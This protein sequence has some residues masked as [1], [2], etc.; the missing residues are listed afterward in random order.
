MILHQTLQEM[1]LNASQTFKENQV[2]QENREREAAIEKQKFEEEIEK[3]PNLNY[4]VGSEDVK[5]IQKLGFTILSYYE[6][7]HP[8][9]DSY[10]KMD[11][12]LCEYKDWKFKVEWSADPDIDEGILALRDPKNTVTGEELDFYCDL[13]CNNTANKSLENILT[14]FEIGFEHFIQQEY[15]QYLA[16]PSLL[17]EKGYKVT[18]HDFVFG[19]EDCKGSL[20]IGEGVFIRIYGVGWQEDMSFT[21]TNDKRWDVGSSNTA[22]SNKKGYH[23]DYKGKEDIDELCLCIE[24]F[25]RHIKGT[26]GFKETRLNTAE[27][28]VEVYYKNDDFVSIFESIR[29]NLKKKYYEKW[30]TNF[31]RYE[32]KSKWGKHA[33]KR[34]NCYKGIEIAKTVT[35]SINDSAQWT[36]GDKS[37]I[38]Q[39]HLEYNVKKN[40]ESCYLKI[41]Q[42][43]SSEEERRYVEE[44]WDEKNS[45]CKSVYEA[46]G[47]FSELTEE[48]KEFLHENLKHHGITL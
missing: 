31:V 35:F 43:I 18:E 22:S 11:V 23:F 27:E 20:E 2:M 41:S 40:V 8:Y 26:Y 48:V 25:K 46:Y 32:E 13:F 9:G 1:I 12:Y 4:N 29:R 44:Q 21:I 15:H 38:Y 7:D 10:G 36:I 17:R 47:S 6:E 39:I 3:T 34:I 16:L 28:R 42:Y 5:V 45:Y 33:E 14:V 24:G 37:T 30:N 19:I